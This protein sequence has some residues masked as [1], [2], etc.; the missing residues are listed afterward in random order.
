ME[1]RNTSCTIN[2]VTRRSAI[3]IVQ[4]TATA[5]ASRTAG[6]SGGSD[7]SGAPAGGAAA[8]AGMH[9]GWIIAIRARHATIAGAAG[10][11][12]RSAALATIGDRDRRP[13]C[14]QQQGK[15]KSR[16]TA[17][18]AGLGD[19]M[20]ISG[21]GASGPDGWRNGTYYRKK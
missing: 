12:A 1:S 19:G 8:S 11:A 18:V 7:A 16:G 10:T 14:R 17:K 4:A 15:E 9:P 2:A 6:S 21:R 5:V 13:A 3:L 20:N